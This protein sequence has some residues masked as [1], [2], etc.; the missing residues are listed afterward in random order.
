MTGEHQCPVCG[1]GGLED[2]A[3]DPL[4]GLGSYQICPSCGFEYGVTDDDRQITHEQ[5][6]RRWIDAGM[7][8]RD[9]GVSDAP[10]DWDASAQL[11]ALN[12]QTS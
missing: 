10:R 12:D 11:A 2:P 3:Y 4:T 8:W 9:A 5:W 6:R 1:F 7:P